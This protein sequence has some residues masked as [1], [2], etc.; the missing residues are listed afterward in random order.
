MLFVM[1]FLKMKTLLT[2]EPNFMQCLM[3]L[4]TSQ[5]DNCICAIEEL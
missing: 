3:L 5:F 1:K 2:A 4:H